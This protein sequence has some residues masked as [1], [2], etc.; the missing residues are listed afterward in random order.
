MNTKDSK[1]TI[2][3]TYSQKFMR[4]MSNIVLG[5]CYISA[6]LLFM[7]Y[8]I[9]N[10]TIN[11]MGS[12]MMQAILYCILFTPSL[13]LVTLTI[14]FICAKKTKMS[15]LTIG[16]FLIM[17]CMIYLLTTVKVSVH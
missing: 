5:V 10:L 12:K 13:L 15:F 1:A 17:V 7:E 6:G 9:P 11:W 14:D 16:T 8:V 4:I 2:P 3:Y